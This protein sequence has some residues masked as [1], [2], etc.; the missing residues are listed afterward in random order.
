MAAKKPAKKPKDFVVTGETGVSI[1]TKSFLEDTQLSE[2]VT[3]KAREVLG[4]KSNTSII[5]YSRPESPSNT[6]LPVHIHGVEGISGS[7]DLLFHNGVNLLTGNNEDGKTSATL[8]TVVA[9]GGSIGRP[10]RANDSTGS[11]V[12]RGMGTVL[13]VGGRTTRAGSPSVELAD[14]GTLA[15]LI[16]PAGKTAATRDKRRVDILMDYAQAPVTPE[17]LL[18]MAGGDEEIAGGVQ[19]KRGEELTLRAAATAVKKMAEA[20]ARDYEQREKLA[21]GQEKAKL[22]EIEKLKRDIAGYPRPKGGV[23]GAQERQ[24][25]AVADH[26]RLTRDRE[27]RVAREQ[28]RRQWGEFGEMPDVESLRAEWERVSEE[29]GG[30]E[31]RLASLRDRQKE[32]KQE[33]EKRAADL[34]EWERRKA[35]LSQP[36]EGPEAQEVA[37]AAALIVTAKGDLEAAQL[38]ET[39]DRLVAEVAEHRKDAVAAGKEAH[40]RRTV[41]K[42]VGAVVNRVIQAED[43]Q[44]LA[45]DESDAHDPEEDEESWG[46]TRWRLCRVDPATGMLEPFERLSLGA[47]TRLVLTGIGCRQYPGRVMPLAPGF[48]YALQPER[49]RELVFIAIE[50]GIKIISEI[51]TDKAGVSLVHLGEEWIASGMTAEEWVLKQIG[52]EA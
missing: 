36:I 29:I 33:G 25:K 28:E 5:L 41:A 49:Q 52:G 31:E 19:G 51:P 2:E 32:I 1:K 3:A 27:L 39:L 44:G 50:N 48:W 17:L 13:N 22:V 7:L 9:A 14:Y 30:L 15:E 10:L 6:A 37:N 18:E 16:E 34:V 38:Y 12:V 42:G 24:E 8:A 11:G 35:S 43:L 23:Q 4:K 21:Q 40:R 46:E 20:V 26:A 45:L 47:R